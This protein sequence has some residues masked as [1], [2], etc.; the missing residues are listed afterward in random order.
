MLLVCGLLSTSKVQAQDNDTIDLLPPNKAGGVPL[1]EAIEKRKSERNFRADSIQ[2]QHL[3]DILWVAF[4]LNREDGKR[5]IPTGRGNN[6]LAVYAVLSSGVYLYEPV[7]HKLNKVLNG[8][9]TLEY[10]GAPLTLL[11]AGPTNGPFGA[12]HAGSAYQNVGLYCASEGLANVVKTSGVAALKDTLK[13]VSNWVVLVV[14]S[15]GYP[16]DA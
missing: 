11:Y 12:L 2:A 16:A 5:T 8:D 3:S 10:G 4:G 6:E 14:Q 9:Y 15:I 13:P 1:M 7:E